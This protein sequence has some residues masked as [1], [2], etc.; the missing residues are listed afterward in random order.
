MFSV[1]C[2][3]CN[4][5]RKYLFIVLGEPGIL[6]LQLVFYLQLLRGSFT[7]VQLEHTGLIV[8]FSTS[9]GLGVLPLSFYQTR[10]QRAVLN[11]DQTIIKDGTQ[12]CVN[13]AADSWAENP[14]ATSCSFILCASFSFTSLRAGFDSGSLLYSAVVCISTLVEKVD[15]NSGWLVLLGWGCSHAHESILTQ[16]ELARLHITFYILLK[17]AENWIRTL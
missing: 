11:Q 15:C 12:C 1:Q 2:L 13:A 5:N 16:A 7:L 9:W 4:S 3:W 6:R 17:A 8:F 14:M 10:R